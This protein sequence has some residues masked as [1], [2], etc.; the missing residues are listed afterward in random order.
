MDHESFLREEG[1]DEVQGF[2]Y[3]RPLTAESF[4][5]YAVSYNKHTGQS[6]A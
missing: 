3:T 5:D 2:K 1:C 4:W 6:R